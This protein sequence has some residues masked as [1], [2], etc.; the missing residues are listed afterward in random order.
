MVPRQPLIRV[1]ANGGME[2]PV[3]LDSTNAEG[4]VGMQKLR[5][6]SFAKFST[7]TLQELAA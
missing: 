4:G 2:Q 3:T 1:H 6:S 5:I 7:L